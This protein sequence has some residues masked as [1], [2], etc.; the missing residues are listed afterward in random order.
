MSAETLSEQDRLRSLAAVIACISVVG[1][2]MGLA[3]P[4]LSLIMEA[5][6]TPRTVIGLSSAMPAIAMLIFSPQIPRIVAVIGLKAFILGCIGTEAAMFAA[7]KIV[8]D[9]YGWFPIRFVM[10]ASAAGLFIASETWINQIAREETRARLMAIYSITLSA[11]V[12]SGPIIVG[13][14]GIDGWLPFL[15]GVGFV[16]AAA[17]PLAWTG[18]LAPALEGRASFGVFSFVRIAPSL[19]AA[20]L[21][22]AAIESTTGA[23]LP[24]YGARSGLGLAPA[25]AMMTVVLLGSMAFQLPIGWLADRFDRYMVLAWLGAFSAGGAALLPAVVEHGLLLW[26][27]LFLW[28]GVAAGIYTVA[29]A[30]QGQRFRG[31]ELITANAAFGVLWGF[32]SIAGPAAGGIAMDLWDPHG[33]AVVLTAACAGFV[34][35]LGWRRRARAVTRGA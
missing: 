34:A 13:L 9:V 14:T 3:Y 33:L 11:G 15:I 22:F 28:G 26:A 17:I 32:G 21:L 8:D 5:R 6:G 29:L 30:I 12:A 16:L 27:V 18:R 1:V 20:V 24:V 10:G 19:A 7:L 23:L 31:A 25:A 4:L 2:T 35:I